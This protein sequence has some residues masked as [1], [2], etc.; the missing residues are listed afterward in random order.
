M[1]NDNG[2]TRPKAA[3]IAAA[4]LAFP[5]LAAAI[6]IDA[7]GPGWLTAAG[8]V[9]LALAVVFIFPPFFLLAR[10]GKPGEGEPF[11]A[12][13]RVADRGL[14]R[15]VRHPQ[16]LGYIFLVLG[17]GAL[18]PHPAILALAGGASVFFYVQAVLEERYCLEALGEEYAGYMRRVPRFNFVLGLLRI[19]KKR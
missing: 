1:S 6:A 3:D 8:V 18:D 11:F 15:I 13:T 19:A 5:L 16:Y 10:H 7:S 9:L 12:T 2:R 17:F 4:V 14:Y